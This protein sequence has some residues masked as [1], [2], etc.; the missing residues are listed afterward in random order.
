[1]TSEEFKVISVS[2]P[3]HGYLMDQRTLSL[4]SMDAVIWQLIEDNHKAEAKIKELEND[5]KE[6]MQ[7]D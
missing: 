4:K 2:L 1:M 5:I 3:T 6:R 7:G